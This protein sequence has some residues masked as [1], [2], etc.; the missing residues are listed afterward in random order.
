MS[1]NEDKKHLSIVICGHVDS[2]KSTTTGRLIFDSGGINDRE[3]KKL[4]DEADR[5]GK[6]SFAFAF[7]WTRKRKSVLVVLLLLVQPRSFILQAI[8]TLLLMLQ[9]IEILLRI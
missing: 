9:A 4:Q 7:I 8:I 1:A 6:S 5:L 2:G 3:M